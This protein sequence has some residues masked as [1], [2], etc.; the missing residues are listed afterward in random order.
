MQLFENNC[1]IQLSKWL[2]TVSTTDESFP[3]SSSFQDSTDQLRINSPWVEWRQTLW[4]LLTSGSSRLI[5]GSSYGGH[6]SSF[7]LDL[8]VH[9]GLGRQLRGKGSGG[10]YS[11]LQGSRWGFGLYFAHIL[12]CIVM[13]EKVH[14][15]STQRRLIWIFNVLKIGFER[16]KY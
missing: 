11:T 10:F 1:S 15:L 13:T 2:L 9:S 6:H 16:M 12:N 3:L 7:G 4:L 8:C 14:L 5:P